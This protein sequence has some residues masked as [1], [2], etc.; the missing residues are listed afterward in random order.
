MIFGYIWK[1][2]Q[3]LLLSIGTLRITRSRFTKHRKFT[4]VLSITEIYEGLVD[5]TFVF[6]R[7]LAILH[8]LRV[9]VWEVTMVLLIGDSNHM[10]SFC[11][12]SILSLRFVSIHRHVIVMS[13]LLVFKWP[14]THCL[15]NRVLALVVCNVEISGSHN[16]IIRRC[17]TWSLADLRR[18][19]LIMHH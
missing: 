13:L 16:M 12:S 3:Q 8:S 5:H 4:R 7:Y 6:S 15:E 18:Q 2:S 11:N 1:E 17:A 19:C 10:F 14:I 9:R